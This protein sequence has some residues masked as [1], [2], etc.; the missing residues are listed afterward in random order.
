MSLT[1]TSKWGPF[2][3]AYR[4]SKF[5]HGFTISWAQGGEDIALLTALGSK[6][7][8]YL[9]IGAH[10]PTRFSV[11]RHLYQRGWRGVHVD[12][13]P[14][15]AEQFN[16]ERPDEI[17]I[18]ACV[19]EKSEYT[20][21]IFEES[22]ISTTDQSWAIRATQNGNSLRR[23]LKVNGISARKLID[24]YGP[25][26]LITID[27]EG[28]DLEVI[29]SI[30]FKTLP[31]HSRPKIISVEVDPPVGK[32]LR[33]PITRLLKKANYIPLYILPMSTFFISSS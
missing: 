27:V 28:M 4:I 29:K 23:S 31:S 11:S 33:H 20:F 5:D 14:E 22:A 17:F 25:F 1:K 13:N 18:S 3:E 15:L 16:I 24:N 19:G 12:A 2:I 8:R 21:N 32:V 10:H 7:G 26:D 30:D 9:D 6:T